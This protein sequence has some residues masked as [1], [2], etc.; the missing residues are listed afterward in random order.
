[1]IA[2]LKGLVEGQED[3]AA[4]VDVGGVVYRALCSSRTLAALPAKGQ[5]MVLETEYLVIQEV[6]TLVGFGALAEL[7]AF[8]LLVTV[9]GVGPKAALAILSVHSPDVLF[10]AIANGDAKS[11]QAA[12]GVGAKAAARIITDLRDKVGA[13]A[14]LGG[15]VASAAGAVGGAGAAGGAGG[16]VEGVAARDAVSALTNLGYGQP[17][18]IRAVSATLQ[19]DPSADVSALIRLALQR[20][21]GS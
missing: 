6:P 17:E 2:K 7:E 3:G 11:I 14:G 15:G 21:S 13:F 4:L 19:D 9:N 5:P 8:R 16:T 10:A 18:A 1:M 20:L 12:K